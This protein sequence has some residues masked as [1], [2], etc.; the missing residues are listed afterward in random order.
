MFRKEERRDQ[1]SSGCPLNTVYVEV[2]AKSTPSGYENKN[3]RSRYDRFFLH[4]KTSSQTL[5]FSVSLYFKTMNNS[6]TEW[7]APE[8]ELHALLDKQL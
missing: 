1:E 7:E 2:Y 6:A 3:N 4:V 5:G 8:Q